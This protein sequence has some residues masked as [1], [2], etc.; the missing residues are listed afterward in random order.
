MSLTSLIRYKTPVRERMALDFPRPRL[1]LDAPILV[2]SAGV[3]DALIG[4]AFDYLLRFHVQRQNRHAI[5]REWIAEGAHARIVEILETGFVKTPLGW[6]RLM[7]K[8]EQALSKARDTMAGYIADA[9]RHFARFMQ[10][11]AL[12][13]EL[14]RGS[15]NLARCD[16]CHRAGMLGAQ[17]GDAPR[18]ADVEQLRR[19]V[20]AT[21]WSAFKAKRVCLLNPCFGGAEMV[22]GADADLLLDET[23]IE[24]KTTADLRIETHDWRQLIGYAALNEHFPVGCGKSLPIRRAGFYFSRHAYLV[25]WPMTELVDTEKFT[26]F[27]N[28]LR[29]YA[30][31]Q[32]AVRLAHEERW[33]K[34]TGARN[35][36]ENERAS[37]AAR[38]NRHSTKARS[39]AMSKIDH[40][41]WAPRRAK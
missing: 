6:L 31:K 19:L 29:A 36:K 33:L 15:L 26:A 3:N 39:G 30:M 34:Y 5:A 28:W 32:N 23:L 1:K 14:L 25:T 17:L 10:G 20:V 11:G 2:P 21:D 41:R 40:N 12:S 27:A 8:G 16:M 35:A 7:P 24:V 4:T 18:R 13:T 38:R 37:G 22:G 9:K